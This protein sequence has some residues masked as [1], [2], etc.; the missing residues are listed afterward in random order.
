[1]SGREQDYEPYKAE[2]K[3][4]PR[5]AARAVA[6]PRAAGRGVRLRER[7]GRGLRGRRRDRE[8]R[9]AGEGGGHPGDDRDRRPRR[10][11]AAP[12]NGRVR[13]MTTSRGITDTRVYDREGVVERY[14]I[15]PE[16][17]PDFI[18]LKGDTSDNIPGVPGIGDKTAAQL[19]QQY[20][21]LEEVLAHI[22]DISGEKRQAEP[23][24]ER[25]PG[26]P[27]EAARDA[28]ARHRRGH[29]RGGDRRTGRPT[30]R[31]CARCSTASSCATRC[32]GSRRRSASR[33]PRRARRAS[34]GSRPRCARARSPTCRTVPVGAGRC[35]REDGT[36]RWAAA[37]R[38]RGADGDA[39]GVA[40]RGWS[41]GRSWRTTGSRSPRRLWPTSRRQRD[42][43]AGLG[44]DGR[45]LPDRPGAP[46]LPARRADR[47][48]GHRGRASSGRRLAQ[49]GAAGRGRC[50]GDQQRARSTAWSCARLLEEIEL[51]LVEVLYR[52]ERQGVKLDTYRLG[53]TAARVSEEIEELEHQIWEL[54][55]EEFTI[56]S[57]QQLSSILFEKLGA[58]PQAARQDRVLDRRA[59]AARDPR[60]ARDRREDREAGAS[61]RS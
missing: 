30:A 14:G 6:A 31:G 5:P 38:G 49:R 35:A 58:E 29:R 22:D 17:V 12:T 43:A 28:P 10:L 56:G 20:G 25:R 48:G 39:A 61:C 21:S 19:L 11:P 40:P 57:P 32:G 51:P 9:R 53:E 16:L 42:R 36:L 2:R 18:G 33:R 45:R 41:D 7:A 4:A 34:G 37:R 26:A 27:L 15:P 54:A 23:A 59:R 46:A 50:A 24:R 44:H 3:S 13:V 8:P 1:M 55:G 60:R 52:L 47:R